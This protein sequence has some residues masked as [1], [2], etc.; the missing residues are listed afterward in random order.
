MFESNKPIYMTKTISEKLSKGHRDFIVH[1]IVEKQ[2]TLED[3]LQIF[4]FYI[5]N[6]KQWLIQRQEEPNRETTICLE[7]V[8]S[9]PIECK[10]WVMDQGGEGIIILF[11][12]DY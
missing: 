6:N 12:E 2:S 3:Y 8:K 11:P 5:E 1:Y 7:L 4:E 10:V 9:E